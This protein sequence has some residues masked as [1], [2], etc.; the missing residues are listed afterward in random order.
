MTKFVFSG[1]TFTAPAWLVDDSSRDHVLAAPARLDAAA[2][3]ANSDGLKAVPSG[4][5]VGR[6]AAERAAN[7]PYGPF[8]SGDT[9]VYLTW[10]EVYDAAMDADIELVRPGT[11][12]KQNF[13]PGW[14]AL[15]SEVKT[16]IQTRY[17]CI[18]GTP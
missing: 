8:T 7:A 17:E 10:R 4:T 11:A 14:D 6:T 18:N 3:T 9:D 1:V 12:I 15:A 16:E 13:L 5:L 2:F